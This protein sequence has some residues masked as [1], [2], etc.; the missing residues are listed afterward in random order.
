MASRHDGP[1]RVLIVEDHAVVRAGLKML[2]E[3]RA[4]MTVVGEARTAP[5]AIDL[6]ARSRPDIVLLDLDLGD[7]S[8]LDFID[9][10]QGATVGAKILV[11]TGSRS[12]DTY[13]EAVRRG[14]RGVV[15]KDQ[16]ADT[17]LRA[18]EKVHAGELWL[19]RASTAKLL[20]RMSSA[21]QDVD[22]RKVQSLTT[23]EREIVAL[24]ARGFKNQ[25]I[26]DRLSISEITVRHHL[27]SIFSKLEVTDRLGLALYA[28]QQRLAE[29]PRA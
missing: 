12:P 16:A 13:Q 19:D 24:V 15:V 7:H 20:Q 11:L 26:A 22:M 6:A 9:R 29:P 1:V 2:I 10:I 4:G 21:T 18:V 25:E 17:L 23:R 5:E 14:A 3:S 8:G 28:F 27:T